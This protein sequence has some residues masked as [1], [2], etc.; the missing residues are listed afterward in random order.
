MCI[1]KMTDVALFCIVLYFILGQIIGNLL[2]NG[3][4]IFVNVGLLTTKQY[5]VIYSVPSYGIS[6]VNF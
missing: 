4:V 3:F 2:G 6:F 5:V 1:C